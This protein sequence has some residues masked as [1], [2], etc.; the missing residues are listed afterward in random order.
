MLPFIVSPIPGENLHG[1]VRRLCDANFLTNLRQGRAA[2]GITGLTPT[3]SDDRL[4][5]RLSEV[6]G[7]TIEVLHS[8][9]WRPAASDMLQGLVTFCGQMIQKKF[10]RTGQLRICPECVRETGVIHD[11]WFLFYA[12]ACPRHGK[13]LVDHCDACVGADGEPRPFQLIS[14]AHPWE[15]R[16]GRH[17]GEIVAPA[18]SPGLIDAM[19]ALFEPLA[20]INQTRAQSRLNERFRALPANDLMTTIDII[21]VAATTPAEED[22]PVHTESIRYRHGLI[23]QSLSFE[24]CLCRV[25]VAA[26]T[27]SDWPN[28]Y[29]DLVDTITYRNEAV[30]HHLPEREA[31]ATAI[32]QMILF[33]RKG[34]SGVP[35]PAL[36]EA[37]DSYCADRLNVRRRRRNLATSIPV[38]RTLPPNASISAFLKTIEGRA[39]RD[40]VRK[41]YELKLRELT[42]HCSFDNP[43]LLADR[44]WAEINACLEACANSVSSVS[45]ARILEGTPYDRRLLGWNHPD[46]LMPDTSLDSFFGKRSESYRLSDVLAVKAAIFGRVQII[47]GATGMMRL[48]DALRHLLVLRY[49]KQQMLL[50]IKRGAIPLYATKQ[51]LTFLDLLIDPVQAN[52]EIV[53]WLTRSCLLEPLFV[54]IGQVRH[55]LDRAGFDR[56]KITS[57]YLADARKNGEIAFEMHSVFD[58]TR[59]HPSYRY[60]LSDLIPTCTEGDS[61]RES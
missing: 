10:L 6:S 47:D 52:F 20:G 28:S 15:C 60:R 45:A 39:S 35:L 43:Q 54:A 30:R 50:D 18:A 8:M 48:R 32:G 42:E 1:Y 61:V 16:C 19:S 31:F 41:A 57:E 7:Q 46:L 9:R 49:K 27:M 14:A 2:A 13:L 24:Q 37:I 22:D 53:N 17:F 29:Y 12:V 58:G 34:L 25:E 44:L 5:E 56:K 26:A 36:Q 33:P 3:S 40:R 11:A 38:A 51:D 4:W 23:D 59:H 55:L 21:G